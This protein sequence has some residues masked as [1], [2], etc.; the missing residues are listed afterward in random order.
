MAAAVNLLDSRLA[1]SCCWAV[2]AVACLG[3]ALRLGD[4]LLAQSSLLVFA[5][6]GIKV[7]IYDLAGAAP[8]VRIGSL[9]VLG[10]SLYVG[11][12]LYRKIPADDARPATPACKAADS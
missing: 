8:L 3:L 10:I 4:R 6:S 11:G 9:L 5:F 12:W 7:L 2:L 1:V